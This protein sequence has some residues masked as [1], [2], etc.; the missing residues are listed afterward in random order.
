MKE[1]VLVSRSVSSA[2]SPSSAAF[3]TSRNRPRVSTTNGS[4]SR[5][6]IGP[7]IAFTTP[8]IRPIQR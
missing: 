2:V 7:T 1:A 6:R 8:K 3:T 4:D 5:R